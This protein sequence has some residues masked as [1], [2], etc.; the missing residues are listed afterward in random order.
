MPPGDVTGLLPGISHQGYQELIPTRCTMLR[1]D[2]T[3]LLPG[4]SHQGYQV[5]ILTRCSM[6]PGDVTGL[7]PGVPRG[8]SSGDSAGTQRVSDPCVARGA[9]PTPADV[10]VGSHHI[11]QS[12]VLQM[13]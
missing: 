4:V 2:V 10:V 3:C 6:P 9:S 8:R 7:L 13:R 5:F 1:D 12:P 11:D